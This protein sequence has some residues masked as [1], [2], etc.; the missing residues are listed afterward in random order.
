MD[1]EDRQIGFG[2]L[3]R[4][5]E[6]SRTISGDPVNFFFLFVVFAKV[7]GAGKR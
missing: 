1:K 6:T 5:R 4:T 2:L 3:A 7:L